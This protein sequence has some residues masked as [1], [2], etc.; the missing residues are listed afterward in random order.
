MFCFIFLGH[1]FK[2]VEVNDNSEP[3]FKVAEES[4]IAKDR[5]QGQGNTKA[6]LPFSKPGVEPT[7]GSTKLLPGTS[8]VRI[9]SHNTDNQKFSQKSLP[10][11]YRI[12]SQVVNLTNRHS[13]V[14]AMALPIRLHAHQDFPLSVG[15][16][17]GS[18]NRQQANDLHGNK[19]SDIHTVG[20]YEWG[21]FS[22]CSTSCGE[23]IMK[24]YRKC[25]V[26]ECTAPGIETQVVPCTSSTCPGMLQRYVN[27]FLSCSRLLASAFL[28]L[29]T[30]PSEPF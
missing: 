21:A 14:H 23:G 1:S 24:R 13:H 17:S 4:A 5:K 7:T 8:T 9:T 30:Y 15:D 11:T 20:T 26:E 27:C 6:K 19:A 25:S 18:L 29:Y 12:H 2:P 28:P 10:A 22:K 3:S 16:A